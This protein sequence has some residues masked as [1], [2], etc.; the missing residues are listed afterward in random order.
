MI[1]N[2]TKIPFL[3]VVLDHKLRSLIIKLIKRPPITSYLS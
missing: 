2:K 3:N 1:I